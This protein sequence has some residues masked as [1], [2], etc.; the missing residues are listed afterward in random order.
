VASEGGLSFCLLQALG[1][2]SVRESVME[3]QPLPTTDE[4]TFNN[5]RDTRM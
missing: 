1:V 4:T 2:G 5:R 3:Q